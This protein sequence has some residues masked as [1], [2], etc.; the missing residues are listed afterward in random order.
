MTTTP[1][2]N[3][4]GG[5]L[6]ECCRD[7]LTGF[8]RDGTCNSNRHDTGRHTVCAIVTEEFLAFS[9]AQGNDLSTPRPEHGFP[10]LAP[11]N[12]WCLCAARWAEAADAGVGP[13]VVLNACHEKTLEVV[14]IAL[15]RRHAL[16]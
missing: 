1:A 6:A 12:R 7:P 13:P 14:D 11:G 10:G 15:L 2:R 4:L 9:R 3:I 8:L 16:Q 5:E